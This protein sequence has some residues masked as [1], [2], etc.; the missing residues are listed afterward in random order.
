MRRKHSI[1]SRVSALLLSFVMIAGMSSFAFA[2]SK[3]STPKITALTSSDAGCAVVTVGTIKNAKGYQVKYS[4]N[5]NF[6]NST[7]KTFKGPKLYKKTV[8][9]LKRGEKYYIKVRAYTTNSSGKNIYSS[10]SKK[11][12]VV[13]STY[14]TGYTRDYILH[15][16]KKKDKDSAVVSIPY[17]S[18]VLVSKSIEPRKESQWIKLKYKGSVCYLY[19][20]ANK[21]YFRKTGFNYSDYK[22][23]PVSE[24]R[25]RVVTEAVEICRTKKTT[26]ANTAKIEPGSLDSKGRMRF[27]CSGFTSYVINNVMRDYIPNFNISNGIDAQSKGDGNQL[28][29][30]DGYHG[31]LYI[32]NKG[33]FS[34]SKVCSGKP[35]FSKLKPGDL[36]FFDDSSTKTGKVT[37]VGIY[38]GN[39]EFIHSTKTQGGVGIMPLS[40]GRYYDRFLFARRFVPNADPVPLNREMTVG[41]TGSRVYKDIKFKKPKGEDR[42]LPDSTVTVDYITPCSWKDDDCC[43]IHYDNGKTGFI[44]KSLLKKV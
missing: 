28:Q 33:K 24:P 34:P 35:D 30:K 21:K 11:K 5:S 32:D 22:N 13:I 25:Q 10:Y 8:S 17:K 36:V 31:Y 27:D 2:A 23:L 44:K 16:N 15:V 26:Y 6:S 38:I 29:G 7:T 43:Y 12:S 42:V 20:K 40:Y 4:L 14:V 37:H 18:K 9:G 1:L 39:K 3:P 19:A 41:S